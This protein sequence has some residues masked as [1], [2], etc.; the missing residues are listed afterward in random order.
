MSKSNV[1]LLIVIGVVFVI[2]AMQPGKFDASK[3]S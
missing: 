3:L 2:W 1:N